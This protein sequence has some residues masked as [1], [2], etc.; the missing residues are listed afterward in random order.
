MLFVGALVASAAPFVLALGI[1]QPPQSTL[2]PLQFADDDAVEAAGLFGPNPGRQWLLTQMDAD[3]QERNPQWASQ[4]W[5]PSLVQLRRAVAQITNAVIREQA[6]GGQSVV[7]VWLTGHAAYSDKGYP[8]YPL[9]DGA[10]SAASLLTE[11][12]VPLSVAHRVHL[13][14]D[15]CHAG[16]LVHSRALVSGVS[17]QEAMEKGFSDALTLPANVGALLAGSS[18]QKTYEWNGIRAGVFSALV[19]SALRGAADSDVNG[20]VTYD[21]AAA[22]VSSAVEGVPLPSARPNVVSTPPGVDL[23][24]PLSAQVWFT[25]AASLTRVVLPGGFH[26]ADGKGAW[27]AGGRFEA[28][29]APRLWLPTDRPLFLV[30][31]NRETP[32]LLREDGAFALGDSNAPSASAARGSVEDALRDGWFKVPFGPAYQRGFGAQQRALRMVSPVAPPPRPEPAPHMP[33]VP[34]S[35]K[36]KTAGTAHPPTSFTAQWLVPLAGPLLAAGMVTLWT[37]ALAVTALAL[38]AL[39]Q[40]PDTTLVGLAVFGLP[41]WAGLVWSMC[42]CGV[43]TP[44]GVFLWLFERFKPRAP[45]VDE[46]PAAEKPNALAHYFANGLLGPR[47]AASAM[48]MVTAVYL[49]GLTLIPGALGLLVFGSLAPRDLGGAFLCSLPCCIPTLCGAL[50]A[51]GW[52][53]GSAGLGYHDFER[54]L[55]EPPDPPRRKRRVTPRD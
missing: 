35:P 42:L 33:E 12:V 18:S 2:P 21:E 15:T 39:L 43:V 6:D 10:L 38:A 45:A 4:A 27:L 37:G 34:P 53:A 44:A 26:V 17:P 5:A 23:M 50:G 41:F 3:T 32:L 30:E 19:R 24:S 46:D 51:L 20:V 22:Y 16:A 31:P 8:Y 13:V 55:D 47:Y 48:S 36:S 40:R 54:P 7:L 52:C 29:F 25:G 28:E 14:V 9:S 11:V 49:A 1:N